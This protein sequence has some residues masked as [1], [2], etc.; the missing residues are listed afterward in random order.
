MSQS[1]HCLVAT[2]THFPCIQAA[3]LSCLV[4][5]SQPPPISTS[6]LRP[7]FWTVTFKC[8]CLF[9]HSLA[10]PPCPKLNFLSSLVTM[11]PSSLLY[12]LSLSW[13]SHASGGEQEKFIE[14]RL[15]KFENTQQS[16]SWIRG[17]FLMLCLFLSCFSGGQN[18]C[19]IPDLCHLSE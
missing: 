7:A 4:F 2:E 9:V 8:H 14:L 11:G 13:L 17:N 16:D 19:H 3:L 5:N 12:Q 18:L 10:V 15:I 6:Y 1:E